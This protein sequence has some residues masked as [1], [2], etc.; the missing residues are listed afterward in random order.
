MKITF[1]KYKNIILMIENWRKEIVEKKVCILTNITTAYK[2]PLFELLN[3]VKNIMVLYTACIE[4]NR[5]WKIDF[6]RGY[7]YKVL[8][9]ISINRKHINLGVVNGVLNKENEIFIIGGLEN[10]SMVLAACTCIL[11]KKKYALLLDGYSRKLESLDREN[12]MKKEMKKC[13][14]QKAS[15]Y[16]VSGKTAKDYYNYYGADGKKFFHSYLT[17]DVEY[18]Y[19]NSIISEERKKEYKGKLELK[20]IVIICVARLNEKKGIK[21]LIDAFHSLSQEHVNV[22]LL[23]VGNEEKENK[24]KDYVKALGNKDIKFTG[25]ID[26][27]SMPVYYAI[28][29]IF[30]LPTKEDAWGLVINEAMACSLPII[31][32]NCA[33]ASYELVINNKNGIV[34]KDVNEFQIKE[35]LKDLII[36][37]EKR[38][39]MGKESFNIINK[40]TYKESLSGF[41]DAI[42]YMEGSIK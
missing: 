40:W 18:F 38:I 26:Y 19:K 22:S 21:E 28:S 33:G 41:I 5:Q 20:E 42:N 8:K 34:I 4:K 29:D 2:N 7:E 13:I 37:K 10:P 14:I 23:L 16:L 9:G 30:I 11:S 36:H 6:G 17:V 1:Y 31:T 27:N 24:Y 39:L 3:K 25:F 32:T 35:S 15:A 12:K